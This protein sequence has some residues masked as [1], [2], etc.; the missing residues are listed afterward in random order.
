MPHDRLARHDNVLD[1]ASDLFVRIHWRPPPLLHDGDEMSDS[2]ETKNALSHSCKGVCSGWQA[3]FDARER[4][5]SAEVEHWRTKYGAYVDKWCDENREC[6]Q[7]KADI[8]SREQTY[9][10]ALTNMKEQNAELESH[11]DVLVKLQ[12]KPS[13]ICSFCFIY[14][15]KWEVAE[16]QIVK[17]EAEVKQLQY[18]AE[19][20]ERMADAALTKLAE[21]T[22]AMP[23][24]ADSIPWASKL[25]REKAEEH[26]TQ[27]REMCSKLAEALEKYKGVTAFVSVPTNY[28]QDLRHS[29]HLVS[30]KALADYNRFLEGLK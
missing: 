30:D 24:M 23:R 20:Q 29:A 6:E 28:G 9:Y 19:I 16:E 5:M 17:L 27:Y 14:E 15:D 12:E 18:Y 26:L 11:N 8:S 21:T 25:N 7:L 2:D 13:G 3:G 4:E 10:V 22:E 1:N